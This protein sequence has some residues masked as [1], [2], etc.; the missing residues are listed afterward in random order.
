[1]S[2]RSVLFDASWRSFTA[3]QGGL[4]I[5]ELLAEAVAVA[6][7]TPRTLH[8]HLLAGV[9]PGQAAQVTAR[10]DRVATSSSV[11]AELVQDGTVRG[12]A[13]V[14]TLSR[15]S[16]GA[17][18]EPAGLDLPAP[19]QGERFMLPTEFVPFG[20][21]VDIRALGLGRRAPPGSPTESST[22]TSRTEPS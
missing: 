2:Q 3:V 14:M 1:M 20:Q 12:L 15:P 4:V 17:W 11:R 18:Q 9:V 7:G 10:A 21:H 16:A 6:G 5:G 13:Q 22:T 8:A 19:D